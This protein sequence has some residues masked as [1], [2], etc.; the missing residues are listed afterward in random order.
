MLTPGTRLDAYEVLALIGAGGMGEVY[1]ARDTKLNRDVALKVLPDAFT[2]DPDRL[3]RFTREAQVLASLNH[4]NIAAI[5]GLEEANPSTTSTTS[6][7]SG[8]ASSGQAGSGQAVQFLVLELVEGETLAR[9][10]TTGALEIAEALRVMR[11]VADALQAAHEKG[12]VHRDLKPANIAFTADDQVKVLDFGLA[13]ALEPI[14]AGP[15][16]LTRS[17]T[18]SLTATRAGVILGTAAYMS[19]EQ[20]KGRPADKRSDV[21]AFGA[22]FYELL[23]G[24]HA[25]EGED[26]GDTL[27]SVI[28]GEPDWQALP[29]DVP[30]SVRILVQ[31]C[32]EKDRRRRL[33]DISTAIFLMEEPA[34][35]AP[36]P[37]AAAL[38]APERSRSGWMV[39]GA[40]LVTSLALGAMLYL[41]R[42]P[43]ADERG[44]RFMVS[45]PDGWTWAQRA[46]AT[47][48]APSP[49]AVSPDGSQLALVAVGPDGKSQI[50][51]R[52]LDAPAARPL[53]GTDD[54]ARPFWS[55]DGRWIGFFAG[56]KLRKIAASG[57]PAVT[58]CDAPDDR[59]GAW[60]R[61]GVIVFAPTNGSAL[62]KVSASGGTPSAA[63]TLGP[64]ETVHRRPLFL[65]DG[66]HFFYFALGL[67]GV[68]QGVYLASLDS[69]ERTLLLR[70]TSQNVAYSRG[71]V[72]FVR[73]TTL[74]AQPFDVGRLTLNGDA[75]PVAEDI[76]TQN[77]PPTGVFAASENGV[78]AYKTGA[79]EYTAR[80]VWFDRTGKQIRVLGDPARYGDVELSTDGKWASVSVAGQSSPARDIW[81]YDM[82]RGLRTRLTSNPASEAASIWSPD[83]K[84]IIFNSNREQINS[85]YR[86][87]ADGSGTEE[88]LL[89]NERGKTPLGW[90]ADGRSILYR[91]GAAGNGDLFVLPLSGDRKP[92]PFMQTAFSEFDGRHSPD[93]RWVAYSSNE[94][95]Q[96]EVYV[97]PFPGPGGKRR[98]SIGGGNYPRWRGD[99]AE[100]FYLAPNNM[101]MAAAVSSKGA[102]F[103]VGNVKAL[104][105]TRP[106]VVGK[107]YDVSA[108]GQRFL[109]ITSQ[110]QAASDPITIV[111]NWTAGLKK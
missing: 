45:A 53:S 12:I 36:R 90:S 8:Q 2:H 56:G 39:A 105:E 108:D 106:V 27:A 42:A 38:P 44:I 87:A 19:P 33:P 13:K 100:L 32:L 71:H 9:R 98:V 31:R 15:D 91:V 4:P 88:L 59:G 77:G 93:G 92:A 58:L 73:D 68:V 10:L 104:F 26:L 72:L 94:S 57:P 48:A 96:F 80:L 30:L 6:T 5:Y 62:Q 3:A 65:P 47:G 52:A 55:P 79:A 67:S 63:T 111:V 50:W 7:S 43:V 25:F 60:S 64:G 17:P 85:L 61:E 70:D 74:V 41:R 22:V 28:K 86:R 101:L 95:G 109:V 37:A 103:E 29:S 75:F 81:V 51:V 35:A 69:A 54:A 34:L 99:G 107:P 78:L 14:E 16:D 66:R 1:R 46:S 97:A 84:E 76:S 21:W 102:T 83:S 110:E 18:L 20:A 23:T 89:K 40:L 82:A 49:L 11:Q 24:R